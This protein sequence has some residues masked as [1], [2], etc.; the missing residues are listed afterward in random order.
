VKAVLHMRVDAEMRWVQRQK[1]Q[2][3]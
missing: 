2:E 1:Q 3:V